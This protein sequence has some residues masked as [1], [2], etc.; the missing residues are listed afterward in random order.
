MAQK[1]K[2]LD[3]VRQAIRARHL[4]YRTEQSYVDWI[5]RF[6]IYHDSHPAEIGEP[7]IAAFLLF[8]ANERQVSV[9]TQNQ[10]L[11]AILFLYQHVLHKPLN[12]INFARAK[13]T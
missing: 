10:A 7:E 9:S 12:K 4:S 11:Q 1:S 2:L 3:Q 8:L 13:I 6:I 5:Y